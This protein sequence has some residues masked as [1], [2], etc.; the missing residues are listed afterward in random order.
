MSE[1]IDFMTAK[2]KRIKKDNVV[3]AADISMRSAYMLALLNAAT[4]LVSGE[5]SVSRTYVSDMIIILKHAGDPD[6]DVETCSVLHSD[7]S[8]IY[9]VER[10]LEVF[11]DTILREE[12]E[13]E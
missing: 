8:T 1:I 4:R 12:P 3:E 9:D 13:V 6:S 11:K 7:L 10:F 5:H 2:N